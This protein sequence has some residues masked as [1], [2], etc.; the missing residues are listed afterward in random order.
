MGAA[1]S[2]A[3]RGVI[4]EVRLSRG[5]GGGGG[6]SRGGRDDGDGG[7]PDAL[8]R[9]RRLDAAAAERIDF[10]KLAALIKARKLAPCYPEE[11]RCDAGGGGGDGGGEQG[12]EEDGAADECPICM[13]VF[14]ALNRAVCC[15]SPLCTECFV[16]VQCSSRPG[17]AACPYCKTYPL[18]V[19]VRATTADVNV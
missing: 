17:H 5:G 10:D 15:R 7:V 18:A 13:L 1:A 16:S 12:A 19:V 8:C 9:P 2:A 6:G 3:A 14:P 11:E 4:A